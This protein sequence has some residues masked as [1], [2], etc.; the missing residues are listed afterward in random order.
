[1]TAPRNAVRVVIGGEEFTGGSSLTQ[2]R[3]ESLHPIQLSLAFGT[4]SQ[5]LF[6]LA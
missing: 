3:R 1:M 2:Q 5:M 4:F 6:N